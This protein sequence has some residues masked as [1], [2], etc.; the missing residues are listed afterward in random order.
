LVHRTNRRFIA[1]QCPSCSS[2]T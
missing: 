2:T 1:L